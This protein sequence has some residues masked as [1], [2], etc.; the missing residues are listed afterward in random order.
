MIPLLALTDT[1][2]TVWAVLLAAGVVVLLVVTLLLHRLLIA[3]RK[4]DDAAAAVWTSATG[5]ARN[6]ATTWQLGQ[7]A[8]A[9]DRIEQEARRHHALLRGEV[10]P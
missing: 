5:V 4:V 1:E 7:T 3:V 6:T 2:A 9:L 10:S 8:G